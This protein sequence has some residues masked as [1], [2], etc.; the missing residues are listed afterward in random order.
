MD[1]K[2]YR[3]PALLAQAK[4]PLLQPPYPL[5]RYSEDRAYTAMQPSWGMDSTHA[6]QPALY[7]IHDSSAHD[8]VAS[9]SVR[10]LRG[11]P[12]LCERWLPRRETWQVSPVSSRP[13]KY[14]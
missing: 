14:G 9:G 7:P 2:R 1:V 11:A 10:A 6:V 3:P 8:A 13:S 4:I 5:L 12:L